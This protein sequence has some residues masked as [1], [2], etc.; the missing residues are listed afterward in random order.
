MFTVIVLHE[1]RPAAPIPDSQTQGDTKGEGLK[2]TTKYPKGAA[3]RMIGRTKPSRKEKE[4]ESQDT[5]R[6]VF[7]GNP[8]THSSMARLEASPARTKK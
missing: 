3:Q 5:G 7:N 4:I 8:S 2:A 1:A 6:D